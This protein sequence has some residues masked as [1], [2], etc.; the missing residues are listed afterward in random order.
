HRR[1]TSRAAAARRGGRAGPRPRAGAGGA[2]RPGRDRRP[3]RLR[4]RL[5]DGAPDG[6]E[7]LAAAMP[8]DPDKHRRH[9]IRLRS[10]DYRRPG[11]YFVTI[12][13]QDRQCLFAEVRESEMYLNDAGR[14]VERWWRELNRKFPGVE[15]DAFS[16][17][18]ASLS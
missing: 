9:S 7:Q 6:A 5:C 14:M 15:T 8:Y 4:V 16:D 18:G 17:A 11:A 1:R 12:C 13:A 10:Y 3:V 2:G